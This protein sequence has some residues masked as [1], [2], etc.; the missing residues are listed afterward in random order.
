[1]THS[2]I[3]ELKEDPI[4][5]PTG[6]EHK[7]EKQVPSFKQYCEFVLGRKLYKKV[8]SNPVPLSY[9]GTKSLIELYADYRAFIG[10][11]FV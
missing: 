2:A 10:K 7:L 1:M 11:D 9:D 8:M 4:N 5:R 6:L 3:K